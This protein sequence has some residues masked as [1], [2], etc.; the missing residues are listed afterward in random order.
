MPV[1]LH[2]DLLKTIQTDAVRRLPFARRTA[3]HL[4]VLDDLRKAGAAVMAHRQSIPIDRDTAVVF[5]DDEPQKNWA[6]DCRYLLYAADSGQLYREVPARF[7][8]F[9]GESPPHFRAFHQP[10]VVQPGAVHAVSPAIRMPFRIRDGR[11]FAILYSGAS[12]NRHVN[13]LEFLYRTLIDDYGF[14]ASDIQVLNHNG[15]LAWNGAPPPTTWPGDG[16]PYRMK[17]TGQGTK[18]GLEAALDNVKA[19]IT[20]KDLLLIHTNNHGGHDG[21]SAYLCTYSPDPLHPNPDYTA[22][23]FAA[24]LA[25]FGKYADLMVMMEQCHAGGFNDLVIEASTADRTTFAAAATEH[26]SSIGGPQFDPFARDWIAAMTTHDPFGAAL[27]MNPDV[28]HDGKISAQEAFAYADA[29]HDPYDTPVYSSRGDLAY[30]HSLNQKWRWIFLYEPIVIAELKALRDRL[31]LKDPEYT[32]FVRKA[33][34]PKLTQLDDS[35]VARLSHAE[36]EARVRETI[37]TARP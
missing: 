37:R 9:L 12:N 5:A 8:P 4:F 30:A 23:D 21:T 2:P 16:T 15:T 13:D 14:F 18:A 34:V 29:V 19:K 31:A 28:S 25:S 10:V 33:I 17:V 26:K 1:S 27:A 24:K 36:V 20:A 22:K 3:S 7:P 11:R 35:D 32:E 6:H